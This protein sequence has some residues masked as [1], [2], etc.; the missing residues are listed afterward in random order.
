MLMKVWTG[1]AKGRSLKFSL[2]LN[3]ECVLG[4]STVEKQDTVPM[5]Q[6]PTSH[7]LRSEPQGFQEE[8]ARKQNGCCKTG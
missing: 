6:K 2:R 8:E 3:A 1:R 7:E 5:R 4:S